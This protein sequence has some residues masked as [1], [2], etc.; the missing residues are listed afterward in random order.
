M[1]KTTFINRIQKRTNIKIVMLILVI[2]VGFVHPVFAQT[3]ADTSFLD[4]L[5]SLLT[6]LI[7]I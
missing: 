5:S 3:S 4:G 7:N 1:N 2:L 6:N